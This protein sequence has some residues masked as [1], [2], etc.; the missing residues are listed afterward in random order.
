MVAAITR[1]RASVLSFLPLLRIT[2]R[3]LFGFRKFK[4]VEHIL[5]FSRNVKTRAS[6]KRLTARRELHF[7]FRRRVASRCVVLLGPSKFPC[8]F[9]FIF[10]SLNEFSLSEN[11]AGVLTLNRPFPL[12]KRAGLRVGII[13]IVSANASFSRKSIINLSLCRFPRRFE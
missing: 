10:Y 9:P 2:F 1:K 3:N 6:R 4:L 11:S 7:F 5:Y 13:I 12:H 8:N